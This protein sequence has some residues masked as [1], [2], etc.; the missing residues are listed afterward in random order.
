A[1]E[2]PPP[3]PPPVPAPKPAPA[4][5]PQV[6]PPPVVAQVPPPAE[7]PAPEPQASEPPPPPP[8]P[9]V[10]GLDVMSSI[11]NI[12]RLEAQIDR[13]LDEYAKRPRKAQIGARAREHRFA[14]YV[15]DWRQKVERIGTLN[16]PE[17]ARG[18]IYGSLVLTV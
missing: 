3:A 7:A 13:R 2:A 1:V 16:Y 17:A 12:A 10:S 14:Q 15:D 18:R 11:A 8:P 6:E 9:V 5:A 4:P